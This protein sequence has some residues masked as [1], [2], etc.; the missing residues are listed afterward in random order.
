MPATLRR[1]AVLLVAAGLGGAV[2]AGP[3]ATASALTSSAAA[4]AVA[5]RSDAVSCPAV[6]LV[7]TSARAASRGVTE[8]SGTLAGSFAKVIS[9]DPARARVKPVT[10]STIGG[11]K[12][13]ATDVFGLARSTWRPTLT[14]NGDYFLRDIPRGPLVL[15]GYVRHLDPNVRQDAALVL[16]AHGRPSLAH[17]VTSGSRLVV[18][19]ESWPV[20]GVNAAARRVEHGIYAY[21]SHWTGPVPHTRVLHVGS[22][23]LV[24]T[25]RDTYLHLRSLH[26]RPRLVLRA[27]DD[28]DERI[29]SSTGVGSEVLRDGVVRCEP[30][31]L[32]ERSRIAIG[33][34]ARR[35]RIFVVTTSF[36]L[37][38]ARST[39]GM[40]PYAVASAMRQLGATTAV[41]LD[42]GGSV[43]MIRGQ[44]SRFNVAVP[45]AASLRKVPVALA[46]SSR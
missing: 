42:G 3:P 37:G 26:A 1:G 7:R 22:Y 38:P 9:I 25:S 5:A 29:L 10:Q 36:G 4:T 41:L 40:A 21:S 13:P 17:H 32:E 6:R 33:W 15:S 23:R 16:D 8:Y 12:G 11:G 27:L 24:V 20:I 28:A 30:Q 18:G 2:L 31:F 35:S 43:T 39:K 44:R 19:D 46:I 14:V 34:N 45:V